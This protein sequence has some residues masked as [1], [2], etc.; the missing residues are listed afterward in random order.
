VPTGVVAAALR[1]PHVSSFADSFHASKSVS[2]TVATSV[3]PP[4]VAAPTN[5][6]RALVVHPV[7][8]PIA[9]R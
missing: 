1:K 7:F 5:V 4:R 8:T 6:P 9:P 3:R 2:M